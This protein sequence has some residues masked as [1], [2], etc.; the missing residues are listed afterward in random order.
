[1]IYHELELNDK[2]MRNVPQILNIYNKITRKNHFYMCCTVWN[3]PLE[4]AEKAI[5]T[6]VSNIEI[7]KDNKL[8][9]L[10]YVLYR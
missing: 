7:W 6:K 3:Y 4:D 8:L 1:M 2:K 9:V 10:L 5:N